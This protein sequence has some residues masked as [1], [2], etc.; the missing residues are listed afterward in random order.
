MN[1]P[2]SNLCVKA[3]NTTKEALLRF[4]VFSVLGQAHF[5]TAWGTECDLTW[6]K[7][8]VKFHFKDR[9]SDKTCNAKRQHFFT[10]Q[11][12]NFL[13]QFSVYNSNLS[14]FTSKVLEQC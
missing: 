14:H 1:V 3:G 2:E 12:A 11:I 8:K 9:K 7:V 6:R 5:L 10:A 13:I 4:T